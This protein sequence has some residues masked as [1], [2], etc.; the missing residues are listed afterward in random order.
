MSDTGNV[1][2]AKVIETA[3]TSVLKPRGYRKRARN[4]FRTTSANGYQIVNLQKSS[5]GS[6]SYYLN[7]GWD[8]TVSPGEFRSENQCAASLR[9]EDTDVIRPIQRIRGDGV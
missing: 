7:L 3:I 1:D 4:W 6:G 2:A 8:A 9:A 5:W